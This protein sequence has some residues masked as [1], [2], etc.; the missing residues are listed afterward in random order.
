MSDVEN[1]DDPSVLE[2]EEPEGDAEAETEEVA[3]DGA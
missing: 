3:D 1:P 2:G